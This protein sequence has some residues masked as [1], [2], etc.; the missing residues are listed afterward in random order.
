MKIFVLILTLLGSFTALADFTADFNA[1]KRDA[2]AAV[3]ALRTSLPAY[4]TTDANAY[5]DQ[6]NASMVQFRDRYINLYTGTRVLTAAERATLTTEFDSYVNALRGASTADMETAETAFVPNATIQAAL[7]APISSDPPDADADASADCGEGQEPVGTQCKCTAA[8]QINID[9]TCR[10]QA[11]CV[12]PATPGTNICECASPNVFNDQ[13][14][15]AP[16]AAAVVTTT[17]A[18]TTG[19]QESL[20]DTTASYNPDTCTWATDLPRKVHSTHSGCN[21]NG[22]TSICVGYV[23]CDVRSGSGKFVRTATCGADKCGASE[24]VACVKDRSAYSRKPEDVP[25]KYMSD[26]VRTL[27]LGQ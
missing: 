3:I 26:R 7:A 17:A 27:I 22:T 19:S 5:R 15:C 1:V 9:G 14:V 10:P 4:L 21:R 23:V 13:R 2:K 24:A 8:G 16:P 18:P 20:A 25:T 6:V 12:A 11:E